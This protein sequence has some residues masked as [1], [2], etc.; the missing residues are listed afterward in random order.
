MKIEIDFD[1]WGFGIYS[2]F[3]SLDFTWGFAGTILAILLVRK[4]LK[5]NN[6][7]WYGDNK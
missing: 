2:Q 6:L 1:T 5:R 7:F 4:V 3:V